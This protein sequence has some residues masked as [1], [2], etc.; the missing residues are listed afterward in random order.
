VSAHGVELKEQKIRLRN[1]FFIQN[2]DL[3]ESNQ[4]CGSGVEETAKYALFL[5]KFRQHFGAKNSL[6]LPSMI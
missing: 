6:N 3:L 1:I 2:N 5:S 4:E